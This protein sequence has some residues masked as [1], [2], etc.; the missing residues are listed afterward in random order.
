MARQVRD[1][2]SGQIRRLFVALTIA[3]SVLAFPV[4][5]AA[6]TDPYSENKP[7][8][9]PTRLEKEDPRSAPS[10]AEDRPAGG[11]LPV[12]GAE[13][14]LIAVTGLAAIKTGATLVRRTKP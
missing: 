3:G 9:L 8:V 13:L 2:G 5:A 7:E 11:V 6:Q 10:G 12:T 4:A 14:T 1:G